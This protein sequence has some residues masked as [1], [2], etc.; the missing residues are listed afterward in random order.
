MKQFCLLS[1]RFWLFC[2]AVGAACLLILLLCGFS[3]LLLLAFGAEVLAYAILPAEALF[4]LYLVWKL[5]TGYWV[6]VFSSHD[7]TGSIFSKSLLPLLLAG[8]QLFAKACSQYDNSLAQISQSFY[9]WLLLLVNVSFVS[10]DGLVGLPAVCILWLFAVV[11]LFCLVI[12]C[13][14]YMRAYD[15]ELYYIRLGI[16]FMLLIGVYSYRIDAWQQESVVVTGHNFAYENGFSSTDLEKYKLYNKDNVLP[17]L[18]QKSSLCLSADEWPVLDG[19]EAAFPVYATFAKACY[20]DIEKQPLEKIEQYVTFTNTVWAYERLLSKEVDI[21]FG[22]MPSAEQL[23]MAEEQGEKIIL[24]PIGKE[25]F[26]FFV[27]SSNK[28]DSLTAADIRNI[29]SGKIKDWKNLGSTPGRILAFQ[30]P[31]NS[32]SQTLLEHIMGD[33]PLA[34]PLRN[35]YVDS[36]SGI[37]SKVAGYNNAEGAIGFSFRF[38][39]QGM[40]LKGKRGTDVPKLLKIDGITPNDDNIR[41]DA[42]P[43]TTRL[44]AIT[45]ESNK[46]QVVQEFLQWMQSEEG[47][48]LVQEVGY[49]K[50]K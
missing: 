46:K 43:F 14:A 11:Y 8:C 4:C 12:Y 25:A 39:L 41:S 31:K 19:A 40:T 24:T 20:A 13:R 32:G 9:S 21:F 23:A 38:F 2:Q 36:M 15:G 49:V 5:G 28:I 47:Q 37:V 26:V 27:N 16:V 1:L 42:Y 30:R 6:K 3:W 29:Y 10:I 50:L 35:E 34:K 18:E 7:Y 22:A 45:L 17:E 44:Y 33:V 48:C